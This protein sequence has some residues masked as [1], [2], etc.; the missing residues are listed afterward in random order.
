MK[1]VNCASRSSLRSFTVSSGALRVTDPCYSVDTWCSGQI[2]NV[3][4]GTWLAGVGYYRDPDEIAWSEKHIKDLYD[5]LAHEEKLLLEMEDISE[6]GNFSIKWRIE[7]LQRDIKKR[8]EELTNYPGRVAFIHVAHESQI[9]EFNLLQTGVEIDDSY[10]ELSIDVGVDSGQ[11]GFFDLALYTEALS[12][13]SQHQNGYGQ[14][15]SKFE[16]FYDRVCDLTLD[17][18]YQ[19]GAIEF[20]AASMSGYGDG[21]Y[22]AFDRRNADGEVIAAFI[23]FIGE[24]D[25]EEDDSE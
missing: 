17:D 14:K 11:A 20:G 5:K 2:E 21:S 13:K 8:E 16:T 7:D 6:I 22:T 10:T 12:D 9:D 24:G 18:N 3:K 19:F 15:D 1:I 25:D 23:V 4:N